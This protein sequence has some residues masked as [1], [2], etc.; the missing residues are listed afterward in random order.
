MRI[1]GLSSGLN[2]DEMVEK[3]MTAR[4]A[5]LNKLNQQK[6]LTEWKREEYRNVSTKLVSFNTKITDTFSRTQNIDSKKANITGATGVVTATATGE[7]AD[8]V[9]NIEVKNLASATS[10]VYKGAAGASKMSDLYSG[11]ETSVKIG[12]ATIE[13]TADDTIDSFVKKI[14]SNKATGVTAVY[15]AASGSLSL[16][17]KETGNKAIALEGGLFTGNTGF[18]TTGPK[19]GKDAKVIINGLETNQSS[20]RFTI[21]GVEL[22]LTGVSP[23]D[24]STQVEISKDIDSVVNNIK[25][26]VESYNETLALL[27]GKTNEERYRKYLP[28][29]TEQREAMK[30]S[31]IELWDSKAK[32]GMLKNDTILN[33]A[34]SEMRL[35][36]TSDVTLPNGE[37]INLAQFGITTGAYG[38][39]GKLHIDEDKLRAAIESDPEKLTAL[40]SQTDNTPGLTP[41]QKKNVTEKDGLFSRIRKINSGALDTLAEKAGTSKVSS[42]I[43]TAF[44]PQS[45]MGT[46]LDSFERQ[47]TDWQSRLLRIENNY[48]KQFTA[49]ET[50]MNR[51]NSTSSSLSSFL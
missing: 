5:P 38:E 36:M 48:Y 16:T 46:Q 2:I 7:A 37:K 49:M 3:L 8:S 41:T 14:N 32:S 43:T 6:Q 28:L 11:S 23:T 4:K 30:E 25:A 15:D 13:F 29:S 17:N 19:D 51:Y 45:Q 47:I 44:L 35:A 34:I 1:S 39:K 21:N 22:T 26:F 10:I 33:K 20:N 12:D 24:Q 31:E 27:N 18:T 50:A 9:L 42:D 40:F